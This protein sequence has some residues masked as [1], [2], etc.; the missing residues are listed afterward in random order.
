CCPPP[1]LTDLPFD[2]A[3]LS[4]PAAAPGQP[5]QYGPISW[6]A[7]D[8]SKPGR[9]AVAGGAGEAWVVQAG[10]QWSNA[11]RGADAARVA[12]ELLEEFGRLVQVPLTYADVLHA[13]AHCWRDAYPLNPRPPQPWSPCPQQQQQQEEGEEGEEGA[14]KAAAGTAAGTAAAAGAGAAAAAGGGDG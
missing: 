11:R 6:I 1:H 14:G 8:S 4:L 9:P 7:R 2:G 5:P 10:P 13:E 3:L 12:R